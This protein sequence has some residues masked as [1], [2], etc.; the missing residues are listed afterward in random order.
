M[1]TE[2]KGKEGKEHL[3][4]RV[5]W[6]KRLFDVV[7]SVLALIILSPFILLIAIAIKLES[8]GPVI[9]SQKRVGTGYD[10]FTFYKFRTMRQGTDQEKHQLTNLNEYL[11]Q[12]REEY[13]MDKY[14]LEDCPDCKRLGHPCSPVLFIDG[15]EICENNYLRLRRMNLLQNTFFKVKDDPRITR[16]GK[17]LR[18][19]HLDEIPQ[20]YNVLRGDMS[21]VGNRPLPLDEAEHLTTDE[22][23]YRF[24][25]PAGITGLWQVRS[26][27]VHNPEE[28]IA[29]DNQYAMVAGPWTDLKIVLKTIITFF[30]FRKASY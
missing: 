20:F 11:K 14:S 19:Y 30:R 8:K 23:A 29:L 25:A 16:V 2:T 22:W 5:G 6:G 10:I 24:M 4:Y 17:F 27:D 28:R 3:N 9:Y 15:V 18:Q 12:E 26:S 1:K 13:Q 21:V 7:F